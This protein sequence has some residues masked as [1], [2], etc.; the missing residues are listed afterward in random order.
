MERDLI[1]LQSFSKH[2]VRKMILA[3][4][5]H[6]DIHEMQRLMDPVLTLRRECRDE[7]SNMMCPYFLELLRRS[8]CLYSQMHDG[9]CGSVGNAVGCAMCGKILYDLS[10][11]CREEC[12][13][14]CYCSNKCRDKHAKRNHD[15]DCS[16]PFDMV[17]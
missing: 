12:G 7:V 3:I 9:Q 16:G 17:F 14:V 10:V 11:T 4:E 6:E 5:E 1:A 15:E 8:L 2:V 13:R